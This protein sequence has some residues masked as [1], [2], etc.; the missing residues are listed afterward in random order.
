MIVRQVVFSD[1]ST[2]IADEWLL[3]YKEPNFVQVYQYIDYTEN[4][5]QHKQIVNQTNAS[6][7]N[8]GCC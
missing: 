1:T 7:M 4:Y 8:I 3:M 2:Y 6:F 5:Q